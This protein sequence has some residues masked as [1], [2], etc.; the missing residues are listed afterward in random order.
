MGYNQMGFYGQ[1]AAARV[2]TFLQNAG[3]SVTTNVNG[4][5]LDI[6]LA[7]GQFVLIPEGQWI[8]MAGPYSDVQFFDQSQQRWL[9]FSPFDSA[10]LP[11]SSDGTNYRFVNASGCPIGAVVTTAG[12][13]LGATY[14]ATMFTPS[15]FWQGGTFTAQATPAL[16]VT[17]NTGGSTWNTFIGG[18]ITSIATTTAGT[19]Y[20]VIPKIVIQPPAAQGSQPFIPATA[21]CVLS[22]SGVGSIT[23]TNQGAGYV[24]AP[25]I[26]VINQ[27]GDTTGS[28]AVAT[29]TLTGAGQVTAVINNTLG[30]V[31]TA[32]PTLAFSGASAPAS[33][34]ATVLMNFSLTNAATGTVT[35]GS[36]YTGGYQ[37]MCCGGINTAAT[38][39]Y[40]NPAIEKGICTPVQPV[41]YSAS[42]SFQNMNSANTIITFGG[43]GYQVV[44]PLLA[45]VGITSGGYCT[46]PPVGGYNDSCLLY[47]V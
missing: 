45:A 12:T 37:V 28:G 5:V 32:V 16:V 42:T 43:V 13:T 2:A 15:G 26:L 35:A 31:Q 21:T 34:A 44:P 17:A 6:G 7:P 24:A 20:T 29:A 4:T 25:T 47:P 8:T 39:T 11:I 40:T 30:T 18:A 23:V 27:P 36:G 14:P 9:A 46:A 10:P 33:A 1:P 41:I 19:G 38:A 3:Q 22:G